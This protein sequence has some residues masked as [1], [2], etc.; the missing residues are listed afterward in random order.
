MIGVV[1]LLTIAVILALYMYT[2]VLVEMIQS[3]RYDRFDK[4]INIVAFVL[5]TIIILSGILALLGI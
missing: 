2:F 3:I 5:M 1:V 4:G